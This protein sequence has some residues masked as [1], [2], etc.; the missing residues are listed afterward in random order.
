MGATTSIRRGCRTLFNRFWLICSKEASSMPMGSQRSLPPLKKRAKPPWAASAF[1][2]FF[3]NTR[4]NSEA[5]STALKKIYAV[6]SSLSDKEF[7][8]VLAGKEENRK[9]LCKRCSLSHQ[10]KTLLGSITRLVSQ[11]GPKLIIQA[12]ERTLEKGGQYILL[13]SQ[14]E[15]EVMKALATLKKT[16][17]KSQLSLN[18]EQDEELAHLI[19]AGAHLFVIPSLF[20]PCGLTQMIAMRYG[21]IPP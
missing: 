17:P 13:G 14:P 6:S 7:A 12:I 16:Y 8:A 1:M 2:R 10:K 9:E 5:S 20:E 21:S 3:A 4:T 11:K 19:Y 15:E 18:F